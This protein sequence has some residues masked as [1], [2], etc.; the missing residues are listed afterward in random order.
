M[1]PSALSNPVYGSPPAV[2]GPVFTVHVFLNN[3]GA[4]SRLVG[5]TRILSLA[6]IKLT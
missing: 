4:A 1:G 6:D 5:Q 3:S 2:G